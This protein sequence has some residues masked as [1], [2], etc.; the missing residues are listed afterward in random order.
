MQA[1]ARRLG[2]AER[3]RFH[4]FVANDQL[5]PFFHRAHLNLVT[6]RYESQSVSVLEAAAAGLPTVGTAVGLLTTMAPVAAF[7]RFRPVIRTR[8]PQQCSL[9][10]DQP[11]RQLMG[12]AAQAFARAHDVTNT[13]RAFD[14]IYRSLLA[15]GGRRSLLRR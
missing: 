6:S 7:R 5:G 15:S 2:I 14:D 8:W 9:L 11:R 13:A 10:L 3:V 12:D 4:G 1:L